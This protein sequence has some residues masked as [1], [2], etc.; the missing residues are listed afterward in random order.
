MGDSYR[1]N[2]E[3][4]GAMERSAYISVV[5]VVVVT[6]IG[7]FGVLVLP[8][9]PIPRSGTLWVGPFLGV[10]NRVLLEG[11]WGFLTG[12]CGL[13]MLGRFVKNSDRGMKIAHL[14]AYVA[15]VPMGIV[16]TYVFLGI[17]VDT[18]MLQGLFGL[19][20][21]LLVPALMVG[22]ATTARGGRRWSDRGGRIGDG[23]RY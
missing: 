14:V 21:G 18:P 3:T 5:N 12:R 15:L 1:H 22:S 6:M 9:G 17:P 13:L 16:V 20:L 4:Q 19:V 2:K 7:I 10:P 11:A 8:Y 23:H